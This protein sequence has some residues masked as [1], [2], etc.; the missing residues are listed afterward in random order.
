MSNEMDKE[1]VGHDYDGIKEYDNPLPGWWL[2]T[3]YGTIIFA[4]IYVAHYESGSGNS[5]KK[6]LEIAL[7]Q[8]ETLK[9][10]VGPIKLDS[11]EVLLE[12][13]KDPKLLAV[14]A[15][16]F[17]GKCA[18]CHGNELQG[19]IGPNLTDNFWIHGK[20]TLTD[21][22][23]TIR[24]GVADKGMPPWEGIL[25]NEEIQALASFIHS[26]YGSQPANPKEPQGQKIE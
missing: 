9:S 20:G 3:F 17:Q 5:L 22:I 11:E 10:S 23:T 6:D 25:K 21:V 7:A 1:I 16:Q 14:G 13:A 19:L 12:K 15:E 24:T 26:K 4:F 2:L 8:I 18:S